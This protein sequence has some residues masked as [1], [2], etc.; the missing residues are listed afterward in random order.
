VPEAAE[1]MYSFVATKGQQQPHHHLYATQLSQL[2]A[3]LAR[4][5]PEVSVVGL[6]NACLS[7]GNLKFLDPP[8]QGAEGGWWQRD[9]HKV[10]LMSSAPPMQE[11]LVGGLWTAWFGLLDEALS[12][13]DG[14]ASITLGQ[15]Y[16][17]AEARYLRENSYDVMN[18][19][20]ARGYLLDRTRAA[21]GE[22]LRGEEGIDWELIRA[23]EEV[24]GPLAVPPRCVLCGEAS[25]RPENKWLC[26]LC[27]RK[28]MA[29]PEEER[30]SLP[31]PVTPKPVLLTNAVQDALKAVAKP[32]VACGEKSGL[33]ETRLDLVWPGVRRTCVGGA[34]RAPG[35]P[36]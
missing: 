15:L 26:S 1:S 29:V 9:R 5:R 36:P 28:W 31:E 17:S 7:G 19:V 11:A 6:F 35:K 27:Y 23:L 2:F 21:L 33:A 22:A 18:G 13:E 24:Q 14:G 16:A 32:R 4:A 30:E 25:G 20:I 8:R 10:F 3:S 12:A 34:G